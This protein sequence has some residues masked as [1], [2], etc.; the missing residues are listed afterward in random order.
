MLNAEEWA[1][2]MFNAGDSGTFV[3][4]DDG[5][6][7]SE[8]EGDDSVIIIDSGDDLALEIST[9]I[10]RRQTFTFT[11]RKE[12][13]YIA[14]QEVMTNIYKERDYQEA[15]G[16]VPCGIPKKR[17]R[18]SSIVQLYILLLVL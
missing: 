2:L 11:V 17:P 9:S 14:G 15:A 16:F 18:T 10:T 13:T 5:D 4:G 3:A 7:D 8:S 1:D 12:T 6:V